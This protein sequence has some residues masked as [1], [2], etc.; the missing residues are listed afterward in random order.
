MTTHTYKVTWQH[1]LESRAPGMAAATFLALTSARPQHKPIL[2]IEQFTDTDKP[3]LVYEVETGEWVVMSVE[4]PSRQVHVLTVTDLVGG[5][6][7]MTVFE[8]LAP[9]REAHARL[10]LEYLDDHERTCFTESVSE[11]K[12][13]IDDYLMEH[14]ESEEPG[15]IVL[16]SEYTRSE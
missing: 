5:I 3:P 11:Y 8:Y 1:D 2:T 14:A 15:G 9:A 10:L 4:N 7:S 6:E 13:L 16:T 12:Q